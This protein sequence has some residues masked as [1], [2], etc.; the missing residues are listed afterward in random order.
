MGEQGREG[1]PS[2]LVRILLLLLLTPLLVV[3]LPALL[4]L[5][6]LLLAVLFLLF[7]T[8]V[9]LLLILVLILAVLT[10]LSLP[11]LT[12]FDLVPRRT[13]LL[14]GDAD[15]WRRRTYKKRS[16]TRARRN[17]YPGLARLP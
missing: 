8:L 15:S 3:V 6:T 9:V 11:F 1:Y 5:L 2:Y 14:T 10:L 17:S 12:A 16:P 7:A 13:T 4:L